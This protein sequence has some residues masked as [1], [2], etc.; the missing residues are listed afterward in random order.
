MPRKN[1]PATLIW[2]SRPQLF[3]RGLCRTTII[4]EPGGSPVVIT[5]SGAASLTQQ[6]ALPDLHERFE[7]QEYVH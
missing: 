6:P 2:S 1:T 3:S 5:K 7:H 4:A